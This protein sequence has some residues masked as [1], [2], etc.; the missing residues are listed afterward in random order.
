MYKLIGLIYFRP[1]LSPEESAA[2]WREQ[3]GPL[4]SRIPGLASYVQ[5]F[6][7]E[8]LPPQD[9]AQPANPGYDGYM[10]HLYP[11]Q[12]TMETASK[13]PEWQA[14]IADGATFINQSG[15]NMGPADETVV[16]DGEKG[17]YKVAVLSSS[18]GSQQPGAIAGVSRYVVNRLNFPAA[19]GGAADRILEEFWFPSA[20]DYQRTAASTEWKQRLNGAVVQGIW[21]G[22]VDEVTVLDE[23]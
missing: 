16:T 2:H 12:D 11:D 21:A 13:S 19:E 23:S 15:S 17:P 7:G 5:N 8:N 9:G 1:D 22:S 4:V 20:A 14:V 10:W 3:H 18:S 6:V